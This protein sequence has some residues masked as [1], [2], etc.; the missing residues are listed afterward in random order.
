MRDGTPIAASPP[1]PASTPGA[2]T[3]CHD[4]DI[5]PSTIIPP[6]SGERLNLHLA[7]WTCFANA[8]ID[9]A[10]REREPVELAEAQAA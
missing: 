3:G 7:I 1:L 10:R 9:A 2:I 8:K 5:T 6:H 4:A